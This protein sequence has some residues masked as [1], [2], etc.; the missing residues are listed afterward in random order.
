MQ[1]GRLIMRNRFLVFTLVAAATLALAGCSDDDST[2]PQ[3]N[4]KTFTITIANVSAVG[5]F[6][7]SGAFDTPVGASAPSPIGPG[8][9]YEFSFGAAPGQALN[10]ATM[11][12]QSNDL[13]Y[14]PDGGGIAL[15]TGTTPITGDVTGQVML[16]DAGTEMNEEPGLGANQAPRQSGPDTGPADTNNTVR[17]V[18]DG[19]T[20][21][22]VSAVIK[23]TLS[24]VGGGEF[25]LRIDNVSDEMTLMPSTGPSTSVPLAPGVFV[26]GDGDNPLFTAGMADRG[27]GLGALA[28]DGNPADLAADLAGR[29]ALG[30][31][32]APVA[33][34]VH[35]SGMPIFTSG[36]ADY[37]MGLE[38]A[39]EDGDP[40]G[41]A[42]SLAGMSNVSSAGSIAIPVGETAAGPSTPGHSYQ[43]TITAEPG[44]FLSFASMLGQSNDLFF[45]FG[46]AGLPLFDGSDMP[47]T[48][49]MTAMVSL[50]DA[51]TEANQWPGAGSDQ[52]PRQSAPNTGAADPNSAVRMVGDGF[53]YPDV[54]DLVMVTVA[55]E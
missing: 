47:I 28:E 33:Y 27:E 48:G 5:E 39:S 35:G 32:M 46:D 30:S 12:V 15:Y 37:G 18:N 21:P 49:D 24:Y 23:A 31:P 17:V 9:A 11:M 41:L 50:W 54:S 6:F 26:V 51:G 40:S 22:A 2:T 16:W 53:T 42:T 36:S 3:M 10:F 44:D 19:F 43:F 8:Q 45:S 1:E 55:V 7:A 13:F 25:T 34:A 14:G 29:T 38:A 20:Y 4:G 52:A